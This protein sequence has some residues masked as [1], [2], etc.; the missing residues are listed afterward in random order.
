MKC[1]RR[2]ISL[3]LI[4]LAWAEV[5][6]EVPTIDVKGCI[7]PLPAG[8]TQP[9]FSGL[10]QQ[11][12]SI[13]V[14]G[15]KAKLA[16]AYFDQGLTLLW[17]FNHPEAIHSFVQAARYDRDAPMPLW[18]I[19]LA[20]GPDINTGAT[21]GC[22][23][24]A[25]A[26][27]QSAI[28][29][30]QTRAKDEVQKGGKSERE[31]AYAV[32]LSHR[33]RIDSS[34][35]ARVDNEAYVQAMRRLVGRY[36]EDLDAATLY[37]A[38]EMNIDAWNWWI[39]KKPTPE[40]SR[41]IV[42]LND[43]LDRDVNHL[44]ANH[45]VIHALEESP[46]PER[47]MASADRIA[48]LAP[49]AGHIVHMPSHIYRRTGD[50]ARATAVNYAAVAVDRLYIRQAHATARYPLHYLGHNIHFLA[51]SLAIEGRESESLAAA[52]ELFEN[53]LL[54]SNDRYNQLHNQTLAQ[55]KNDYFFAVPIL[56]ATRFRNWGHELM[57]KIEEALAK[58]LAGRDL[59]Y[60]GAIWAYADVLRYLDQSQAVLS[61]TL[62]RLARFW[63]RVD[64]VPADLA[65]GNNKAA[66]LFRLANLV[67]LARA[68]ESL[69][70]RDR[71]AF[72]N[73]VA[74]GI[75]SSV[76]LKRDAVLPE[77][78]QEDRPNITLWRRAV[79]MQ[80]SLSYNEPPDWYYP[81]RESL[82]AALYQQGDFAGAEA[83]FRQ[84]LMQNRGNGRSLF[85]LIE[86]LRAQK[87]KLPEHL[88]SQFQQA[89]QDA[90]LQLTIEEL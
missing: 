4:F 19:A 28:E 49:A 60:T 90:T 21:D 52:Q 6:A 30:A 81:V 64:A 12:K 77:T 32:A 78:T 29:K 51:T 25:F 20:A 57:F 27:V 9:L 22:L 43:V 44:G 76:A 42:A 46:H 83:T 47:A 79:T 68:Y 39:N 5:R 73:A 53:T 66:E 37:A 38:S 26:A 59:P 1:M 15:D 24:M 45:Y 48:G 40:V 88:A 87:K 35:K 34:D 84:D 23:L 13:D 75:G 17:A 72:G 71:E 33:Y 85:G 8:Y 58:E 86:S 14:R 89:W 55:A 11:H 41:A 74:K 82:G 62:Q 65:Y 7:K 67:L 3:A 16:Q 36:P 56:V 61:D 63:S 10:G 70:E 80:D 18:G 2:P 54:F 69:P 50:H 31:L